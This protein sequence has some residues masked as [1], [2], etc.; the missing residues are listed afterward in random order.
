MLNNIYQKELKGLIE[1]RD[2]AEKTLK[3]LEKNVSD[4]FK[5]IVYESYMGDVIYETMVKLLEHYEG[6]QWKVI[7]HYSD[8]GDYCYQYF[9][10]E[11]GEERYIGNIEI[12]EYSIIGK[13]IY[14]DF[15]EQNYYPHDEDINNRLRMIPKVPEY[16]QDFMDIVIELRLNNINL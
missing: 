12:N 14:C 7:Q 5:R 11:K 16:I 8:D 1:K 6:G 9:V 2:E 3:A 15:Y 13:Y 10:N 4:T